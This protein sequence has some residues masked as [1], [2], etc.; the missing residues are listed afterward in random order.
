LEAFYERGEGKGRREKFYLFRRAMNSVDD[1]SIESRLLS[2]FLLKGGYEMNLRLPSD[3][4]YFKTLYERYKGD[5][6]MMG[7]VI[8]IDYDVVVGEANRLSEFLEAAEGGEGDGR[9]SL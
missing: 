3:L 7:K 9:Q 5:A 8:E 6:T 1:W 4:D 2:I